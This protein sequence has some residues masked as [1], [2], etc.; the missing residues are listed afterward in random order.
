MYFSLLVLLCL[1]EPGRFIICTKTKGLD[2]YETLTT[3]TAFCT[4]IPSLR[5]DICHLLQL[6][7]EDHRGSQP[8]GSPYA[9]LY[10]SLF[11]HPTHA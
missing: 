4:L 8:Y 11:E 9:F 2:N 5:S 7:S 3:Q 6:V 10:F 1:T